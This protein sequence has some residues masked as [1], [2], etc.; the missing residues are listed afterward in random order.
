[1]PIQKIH[2]KPK[3][4]ILGKIRLGVRKESAK[5]SLYPSDVEYFVLK[6][7]PGVAQVYGEDPTELDIIFISDD[8]NQ[9]IPTWYKWYAAGTTNSKGEAIGGKLLCMGNGP[10]SE[11]V[12]GETVITPGTALYYKGRDP[13]NRAVIPTRPC[14]AEGCPD[15]VDDKGNKKCRQTMQ[16]ICILPRVSLYGGFQI[17]TGSWYSIESFHNQLEL[18]RSLNGGS[19]RFIP[20]KVVREETATPYFDTRTQK[21][22]VGRH[23]IMK[24][25]P[26][27][28]FFELHGSAVKERL[29]VFKN[30]NFTLSGVTEKLIEGP[31]EDNFPLLEAGATEV[32]SAPERVE[33]AEAL[34][35][36]PQVN[37]KFNTLEKL[38]GKTF[39][40][41]SRVI[42]IRKKEN[43]PDI[44]AAVLLELDQKIAQE[45]AKA[46]APV[47]VVA[48]AAAKEREVIPPT[49]SDGGGIM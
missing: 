37:E 44:K 11:I 5:G 40:Y 14:L 36:D 26:N 7:A 12:N 15:W 17:D 1:M 33:T 13:N 32:L 8:L 49:S 2:A 18:V 9:N 30:A 10:L 21:D 39:T 23:Y 48:P 34:A 46:E 45:K 47:Q 29:A 19:V 41:K 4:P 25:K 42:A 6:D 28:N 35:E 27:E 16:V 22:V 20:F 38:L 3:L 31:M 24:L 43:E